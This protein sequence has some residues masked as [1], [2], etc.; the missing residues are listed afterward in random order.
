MSAAPLGGGRLV[1]TWH[2][3]TRQTRLEEQVRLQSVV[4]DRATEGV[5]LVRA[6]DATIVHANPRFAEILGYAPGELDGRPVAEINWEDEPGDGDRLVREIAAALAA[7][8]EGSFEVR[9]RRKDGSAVW[10]ESHVVVFDHPDHGTV[11]VAVQRDVTKRKNGRAT[12]RG[13]VPPAPG[14][15][16]GPDGSG[17][18]IDHVLSPGARMRTSTSGV[19]LAASFS[20]RSGGSLRV[21]GRS[22]DSP[23]GNRVPQWTGMA[24]RGRSSSSARA[25]RVGSKCPSPRLGPQPQT[26]RR[27]TSRRD[28]SCSIPSK[29]SVS[30][31]K[32]TAERPDTT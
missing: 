12:G 11:W 9:N 3:V 17:A 8:G 32:Y 10:C 28:E 1:L 19:S 21:L 25:A 20:K 5:C 26:G 14:Q 6:S 27:A 7:G 15:A 13:P 31:A 4:L 22:R 24:M 29:R 30:P 23:A 16:L 18:A 2:D